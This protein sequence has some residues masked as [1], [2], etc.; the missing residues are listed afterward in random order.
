[1]KRV[2]L[3]LGLLLVILALGI[4]LT[5]VF[6]R[7]HQPLATILDRAGE[8]ALT[9]QSEEAAALARKA[10]DH[11][12]RWRNLTA[13]VADHEPL[14]EMDLLFSRL[15]VLVRLQYWE[16]FALCCCDLSAMAKAM[17][18][19]QCLAWWNLL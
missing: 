11:W 7:I 18:D 2:Y 9:G 10:G 8:A 16:E 3:G 5:A 13:A 15:D 1:M 19:S 17:A 14:E 6:C 4:C 12:R